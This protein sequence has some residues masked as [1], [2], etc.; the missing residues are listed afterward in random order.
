VFYPA[1]GS[2][3]F[4]LCRRLDLL[5]SDFGRMRSSALPLDHTTRR[6]DSATLLRLGRV[7]NFMKQLL[8]RGLSIPEPAQAVAAA[9]DPQDRI[10]AG[11]HLLARFLA[12]GRIRG[13]T[14]DGEVYEHR[15]AK[16]LAER[17][18]RGLSRITLRDQLKEPDG[19]ERVRPGDVRPEHILNQT[20]WTAPAHVRST[21]T[22]KK[23]VQSDYRF[24]RP[25]T[26]DHGG[27]GGGQP[28]N[29]RN[30]DF[31]GHG[32]PGRG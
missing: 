1:P 7:L 18:L 26:Q 17:F 5:P 19:Q 28:G 9:L 29:R 3:D 8:D 32:R 24:P 2:R 25:L 6:V 11:R 22:S 20:T 27:G 30:R 16:E 10:S 4:D 15:I 14:P 13:L 23:E 21:H 12:D 31:G